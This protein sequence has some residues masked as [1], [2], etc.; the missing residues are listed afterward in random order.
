MAVPQPVAQ[1]FTFSRLLLLVAVILFLLCGL[2]AAGI[3][4][5]SPHWACT[6][7]FGLAAF[8]GAGLVP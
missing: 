1:V 6:G 4:H 2:W 3:I 7:W 8:A 5:G